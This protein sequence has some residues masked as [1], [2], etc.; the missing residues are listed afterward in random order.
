MLPLRFSKDQKLAVVGPNANNLYA[1]WGDYASHDGSGAN[2]LLRD[3][4]GK[5]RG[6]Q[7]IDRSTA[8]ARAALQIG[9]RILPAV[10]ARGA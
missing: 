9:V 2:Q 4:S 7:Q 10:V 5:E 8:V 6:C 1:L 3:P